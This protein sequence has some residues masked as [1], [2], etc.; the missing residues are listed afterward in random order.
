MNENEYAKIISKNLK[1]ILYEQGKSQTDIVKDLSIN[2]ATVSSWVSGTR[3]P[4][5]DKIDLLCHYLN[6]SRSDI[7][8]DHSDSPFGHISKKMSLTPKEIRLIVRYRSASS[9]IRDAVDKLLDLEEKD[10]ESCDS[11][12]DMMA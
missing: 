9:G 11:D 1:R 6:V 5:M 8:E 12:N 4:R 10:A 7:M 3:L 2:K